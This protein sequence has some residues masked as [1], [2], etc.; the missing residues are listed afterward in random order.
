MITRHQ[1]SN[2][3]DSLIVAVS[4]LED[5]NM[6]FGVLGAGTSD[7]QVAANRRRFLEAAGMS[8]DNCVAIR[9]SYDRDDYLCYRAVGPAE[10][11]QGMFGDDAARCPVSDGLATGTPGLALFLPLADCV[12]AV[13]HDP[14]R[15]VVMLS[16][17]GRHSAVQDGAAASLDFM[18]QTY[19]CEPAD[20]AVWL[21]PSA[22][23]SSYR[24]DYFDK[25][26]QPDWRPF[27]Q[28]GDDGVYLDLGG[29]VRQQLIAGGVREQ[30]I[31][32]TGVDTATD[33]EYPSHVRGDPA[34][35]AVA[36]MLRS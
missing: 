2:F 31:V 14:R 18:R 32:S 15:R 26:D 24:M 16:H 20:I 3:D 7:E 34:R 22:A 11:G 27:C 25:K 1:P 21:S 17:L 6:K 29:F 19:G 36:A 23:Q 8:A 12:G 5:G 13:L 30:A 28:E 9:V 35:F 10:R 4:S 33:P